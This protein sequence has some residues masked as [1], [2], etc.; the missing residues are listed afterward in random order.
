MIMIEYL[1]CA[2]HWV[3]GTWYPINLS[4]LLHGKQDI[5]LFAFR[6]QISLFV[7]FFPLNH[8]ELWLLIFKE[9]L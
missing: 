5:T 8:L 3:S 6:N 1:L 4:V 9:K 7:N 2:G